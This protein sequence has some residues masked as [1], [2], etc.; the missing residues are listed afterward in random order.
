MKSDKGAP[1]MP[2][3]LDYCCL[4]EM[5]LEHSDNHEFGESP[6]RELLCRSGRMKSLGRI[7]PG[8]KV[9]NRTGRK[10]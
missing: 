4:A 3:L 2:K 6:L 10:W 9:Q 8:G 5:V 7:F 1:C